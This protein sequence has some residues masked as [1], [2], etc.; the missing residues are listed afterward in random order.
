MLPLQRHQSISAPPQRAKKQQNESDIIPT[1]RAHHRDVS[2]RWVQ[3]DRNK[4]SRSSNGVRPRI[5][6]ILTLSSFLVLNFKRRSCHT[7][8]DTDL[9]SLCPAT[10]DSCSTVNCVSLKSFWT[11][12]EGHVLLQGVR[13]LF[14]S[15]SRS[16]TSHQCPIL[17]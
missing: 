1:Q 8:A 6:I 11:S 10:N 17:S 9:S 2:P 3:Y 16:H 13:S 4:I 5:F 14:L 7:L 12:S 15:G